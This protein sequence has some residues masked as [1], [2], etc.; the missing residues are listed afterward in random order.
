MKPDFIISTDEQYVTVNG[1]SILGGA[2]ITYYHGERMTIDEQ[3]D[4]V[5]MT[6]A[7]FKSF[8]E[9]CDRASANKFDFIFVLK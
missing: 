5:N 8:K 7:L 6:P 2:M 4:T 9:Y 3:E 1:V